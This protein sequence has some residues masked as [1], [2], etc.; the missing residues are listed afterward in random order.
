MKWTQEQTDGTLA[1]G[2]AQRYRIS[3]LLGTILARR[4][5]TGPEQLRFYLSPELSS[6]HNPFLFNDMEV[7]CDRIAHAVENHEKVF[8][9]GDRDVDG[10]TSTVLLK[11]ELESLGLE[12]AYSL[13]ES[14]APYGVS[15]EGIDRAAA[16]GAG[17]L[18]TVDCGISCLDEIAYAG[19]LGLDTMVLDHHLS[20]D[21]LPQALCIINPKVEG[22]GYPF[23]H[24]AACGVVAKCIWALRLARTPLYCQTFVLLHL[25]RRD[26]V[27][28]VDAAKLENL[29][30][31][32]R[33][34]EEVLPGLTPAESS[35]VLNFIGSSDPVMVLDGDYEKDLLREAFGKNLEIN[36]IDLRER[37][38]QAMPVVRNSTLFSLSQRS[39]TSRYCDDSSEL[40]T[41]IA[42]FG[43]YW[44]IKHP[45][46]G[47]DFESILDLVAMGTISDLMPL[48]DEN[49]VLVRLGLQSMEKGNRPSLVPFIIRQGLAG[50]H[51]CSTDIGW[52]LAPC[53]NAAGRLGSPAIAAEMLLA[54]SRQDADAGAAKLISLNNERKRISENVWEKLLPRARR[55][56][57]SFGTK[58]VLIRD[59]SVP[60]GIA[61]VMANRL[62]KQFHAPAIVITATEA[63]M[64]S[65]SMRS[66]GEMNTRDFLMRYSELFD[67]FGG[68][69]YA[70]GFSIKSENTDELMARISEDV[71]Y[72]D[73]PE[74]EDQTLIVDAVLSPGELKPEL[75]K[76]VELFEPYGEGNPPLLFLARRAR[77]EQIEIVRSQKGQDNHL[78]FTISHGDYRW[79]AIWWSSSA[80]AKDFNEGDLVDVA[81]NLGRN[82]FR[83]QE[84]LQLSVK[85]V[86]HSV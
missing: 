85:G 84:T 8:I 36:L 80:A 53:I 83:N 50:R 41:L 14:D 22:C 35:R 34:T 1:A 56:F 37:F 3:P 59:D 78:K 43:A 44:R 57:E 7:F 67:D 33:V 46:L 79:P 73:C 18:I 5:V 63:G 64:C 48:E 40:D 70:G 60:R 66:F 71:E 76:I 6:L 21:S 75:I 69:K 30:V 11:T 17:L 77:I 62:M 45:E 20:G 81:F 47:S 12:C 15:K 23:A 32:N 4:G 26:N 19:S 31:V 82:S 86:E 55:S 51:L 25:V 54:T 68:H 72:L 2:L 49:R 10:I 42:M 38:E 74:E 24:L 13:P 16:W 29:V 27:I 9:F 58:M 65:G 52:K 61:G 39:K 28:V